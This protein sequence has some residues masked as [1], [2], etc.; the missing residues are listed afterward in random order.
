MCGI[1]LLFCARKVSELVTWFV[2]TSFFVIC[3]N[4]W[5]WMSVNESDKVGVGVRVINEFSNW[6]FLGGFFHLQCV[7]ILNSEN[8]TLMFPNFKKPTRYN[9]CCIILKKLPSRAQNKPESVNS[10]H[11]CWTL[12]VSPP[13]FFFSCSLPCGYSPTWWGP[14]SPPVLSVCLTVLCQ[15][16]ALSSSPSVAIETI[17]H[18]KVQASE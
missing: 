8:F 16:P 3:K 6:E 18:G 5:E 10:F 2:S 17:S 13:P 12:P 9:W 4:E 15:A 14:H 7:F 11:F 1:K